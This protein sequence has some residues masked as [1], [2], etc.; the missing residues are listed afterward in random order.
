MRLGV[1][2]DDFTGASDVAN[3]LVKGGL[4]TALAFAGAPSSL[5]SSF[6]A[7]VVAL[8]T[9]SIS[10]GEAIVESVRALDGLRTLGATHY[11]FK[12]CST[13]DSTLEGNIGPVAEAM[14][15]RLG[16]AGP[17]VFCPAFPEAGRTIY[18]GHLFV[19][20]RLLNESGMERHPLNPMTDADLRRW[21]SRQAMRRVGHLPHAIIRAGVP[22]IKRRLDAERAAGRPLVI[23]DAVDNDDLMKLG[24]AVA[25]HPLVTGASGIAMGIAPFHR[26]PAKTEAARFAP[27]LGPALI[28]TGSCSTATRGQVAAYRAA[29][30]ALAIDVDAAVAGAQSAADVFAFVAKHREAAPLVFSSTDPDAVHAAQQRYG[31]ERVADAIESIMAD[32]AAQAVAAGFT[33]LVVA[34]GETSGAVVTRLGDPLLAV[35]PEIDVGVPALSALDRNLAIALKSGNFGC[36]DFFERAL[37]MLGGSES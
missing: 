2:A 4:G 33:R 14:M 26:R 36:P 24:E 30:P 22:E 21:L 17:V 11:L 3:T 13:F 20:D 37:A 19:H 31:T 6:D 8:K 9:R 32:V 29:H 15:D 7:C 16:I 12:Y 10:F 27:A 35:G 23:A 28:L 5:P 18:Q 1:I 34:G 25:G